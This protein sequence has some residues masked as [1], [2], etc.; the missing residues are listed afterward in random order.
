MKTSIAI[1]GIALAMTA[2]TT[3]PAQDRAVQL[4]VSAAVPAVSVETSV[5]AEINIG[6]TAKFVITVKNTGQSSAEGVSVQSTI[7]QTVDFLRS[8]P[9]PSLSGA[10]SIQFDIG[11][12]PAG[13]SRRI[14]IDLL[15]RRQGPVDLATRV[16]SA[17]STQSA[18]HVRQPE[19]VIDCQAPKEAIIGDEICYCVVVRNVGDGPARNVVIT[20][21]LP[22]SAHLPANAPRAVKIASLPA[23]GREEHCIAARAIDVD[24]LEAEFAVTSQRGEEIKCGKRVKILRPRLGVDVDGSRFT[25]L[26]REGK[27][28]LRVWNPGDTVLHDVKVVLTL[29]ADLQVTTLST[30]ARVDSENNTL[31]WCVGIMQPGD[32]KTFELKARSNAVGDQIQVACADSTTADVSAT[33][34]HRT[35]VITR[36]EV[37]VAVLN[38]QEALE[39]GEAE[40]FT[41][42]M[43]N[44]GSKTA[45]GVSV[46]VVFPESLRP[47]ASEAYRT[48]AKR[49][50]YPEFDLAPGEERSLKF[51]AASSDAGEYAVQAIVD[52]RGTALATKAET[53]V[54]FFDDEEL[55]RLANGQPSA[56]IARSKSPPTRRGEEDQPGIL[57]LQFSSDVK[58]ASRGSTPKNRGA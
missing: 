56:G 54:Y 41:V 57:R 43:R 28:A 39:V 23:N 35:V 7:P 17:A 1:I 21:R 38:T 9:E 5:P 58:N 14:T 40:E 26:K 10:R 6:S 34:D 51:K 45:R 2:I 11:N 27:Y 44:L 47:V 8:N 50:A 16:F 18:L 30:A 19:I 52:T 46:Q 3:I 36:P 53:T 12:L 31:L 24:Y 4:N 13:A 48:M 29:P 42:W 55:E 49:L 32:E 33:D 37:D 20:P 25:Y 22:A 15:P